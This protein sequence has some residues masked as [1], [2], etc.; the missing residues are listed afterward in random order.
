MA[1]C[2]LLCAIENWTLSGNETRNWTWKGMQLSKKYAFR[3]HVCILVSCCILAK[4]YRK[5]STNCVFILILSKLPFLLSCLEIAFLQILL[6]G[7]STTKKV[8]WML[9][10]GS[11]FPLTFEVKF[12]FCW[13]LKRGKWKTGNPSEWLDDVFG[14]FLLNFLRNNERKSSNT[15]NFI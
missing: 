8:S 4:T 7:N 2:G 5:L 1:K 3:V 9:S 15:P 14:H 6:L 12:L 13:I 11:T 10:S